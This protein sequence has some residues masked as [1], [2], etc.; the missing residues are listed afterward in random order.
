M[1]PE[2]RVAALG[3][4]QETPAVATDVE[5]AQGDALAVANHF[6]QVRVAV[7]PEHVGTTHWLGDDG[8]GRAQHMTG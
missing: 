7:N 5:V 3:V 6:V 4:I 2:F 8:G 1:T